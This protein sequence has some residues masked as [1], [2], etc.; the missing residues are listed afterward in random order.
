MSLACG[1]ARDRPGWASGV[2]G[3]RSVTVQVAAQLDLSVREVLIGHATRQYHGSAW[4]R[5][6][7]H[8]PE[9]SVKHGSVSSFVIDV[10][11][12]KQAQEPALELAQLGRE[13]HGSS[14]LPNAERVSLHVV[15]QVDQPA[16]RG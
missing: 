16:G 8:E 1:S 3:R 12:A 13:D 4:M 6:D 7:Q 2:T 14:S 11:H 9:V 10:G 15:E 5:T